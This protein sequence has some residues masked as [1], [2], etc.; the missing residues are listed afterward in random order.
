M[1]VVY[2]DVGVLTSQDLTNQ[3]PLEEW[4]P[5]SGRWVSTGGWF[6]SVGFFVARSGAVSALAGLGRRPRLRLK[7]RYVRGKLQ[8]P[9]RHWIARAFCCWP[10]TVARLK[11]TK[12]SR[13]LSTG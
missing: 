3:R 11:R 6:H 4:G 1:H 8:R 7:A 10:A 13:D 2:V 12:Y 9:P 5:R